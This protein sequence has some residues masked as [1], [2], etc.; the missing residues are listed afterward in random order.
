MGGGGASQSFSQS[1]SRPVIMDLLTRRQRQTMNELMNRSLGLGSQV[2]GWT[3][4]DFPGASPEQLA[5]YQSMLGRY[6]DDVSFYDQ[7]Q[8]EITEAEQYRPSEDQAFQDFLMANIN[9]PTMQNVT[10]LN[11][12]LGA[13]GG[14]LGHIQRGTSSNL[15]DAKNRLGTE[16]LSAIQQ[17]RTGATMQE[18]GRRDA[19]GMQRRQM[20]GQGLQSLTGNLQNI[21][22]AASGMREANVQRADAA[23]RFLMNQLQAQLQALGLAG[24]LSTSVGR[25]IGQESDAMSFAKSE[26]ASVGAS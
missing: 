5:S 3:Q 12:I 7:L 10:E 1:K 17:G 9:A 19:L 15:G 14:G 11:R 6:Q 24:G 25:G 8:R 4:S 22:G 21:Y 20:L 23:D 13:E 2:A 26:Q 16:A 18:I